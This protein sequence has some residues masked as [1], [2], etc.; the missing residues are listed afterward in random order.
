MATGERSIAAASPVHRQGLV[1][2]L[3]GVL[4]FSFSVPLTKVAVGGFSPFL[5]ATGRAALAGV[6]AGALLVARRVP[7]PASHHLG[8]SL[9]TMLG[10]VFGWPILWRWRC[11]ARPRHTSQ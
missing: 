9:F 6:L 10:A 8:R 7:F 4:M 1:W 2:A 3:L 5:T 11:S